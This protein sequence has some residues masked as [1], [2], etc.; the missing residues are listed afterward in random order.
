MLKSALARFNRV[1]RPTAQ[2][3]IT[4]ALWQASTG[5]YILALVQQYLPEELG[6]NAAFPG[7]ALA[8][9]AAARFLLQTP[10]GWL[11]DRC[12][13]RRVLMLGIAVSIPSL[14]LMLQVQDAGLFLLFSALYGAGSAAIWPAIMA[15]VG[16]TNE[17]ETRGRTLHA[18]N[19]AQLL[20]LG[21]G[22]MIGVTLL[23]LISYQA[24]FIACLSLSGLALAFAYLG[25]RSAPASEA[26]LPRAGRQ[27]SLSATRKQLLTTRVALL[28]GIALLLS[29]GTTVQAP[30]V[31]AYTTEVLDTKM[32]V[33]G[34]MLLVPGAVAAVFVVRF[35]H[36][37]DKFGRQVP[38]ILGLTVAAVCYFMLSQ[39]TDPILAVTLVAFAGAAYAISVPA[40]GAAALDA[41]EIGGRGLMLGVL[42]TVQGFGGAAGQAIGGVTNAAWGP[43]APLKLGAM[44]LMLAMVLAVMHLRHQQR[45]A[46]AP[47]PTQA[48][49]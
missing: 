10:A 21:L 44:V 8:L 40:W 15:Y 6:A 36:A 42:A 5:V 47:A 11:A 32:H 37:A 38:M 17:I 46:E 31:G 24:A 13:R 3:A 34:L 7:Y 23:D 27:A 14:F 39:T 30:I 28:A 33:L 22:T 19:L 12:G 4:V 20:G 35:G 29:I 45:T 9:Y 43:V 18:L 48:L 2:L 41:T 16:D 25:V 1:P 26:R 49:R